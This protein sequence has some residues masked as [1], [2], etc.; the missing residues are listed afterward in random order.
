MAAETIYKLQP[1]RT[2]HLRG[3]DRRGAAAAMVNASATGFEVKGIFRD[4]A[5]FAVV[6]LWDADNFFE[7]PRLKY[8]P[9]FDFDGLVLQ[10][11]MNVSGVQSI[12]SIKHNWIDWAGI[13][14]TKE[15][16]TSGSVK[17]FSGATGPAQPLGTRT[18]ATATFTV[19]GSAPQAWDRVTLWYQNLA[20]D[21]IV[22]GKTWAEYAFFAA[23]AGHLHSITVG[24]TAYVY[25]E[26][27]DVTSAY[28]A[29]QLIS[30]MGSDPA[31]TASTGSEA[32]YVRLDRKKDDGTET[33]ISASGNL[34][35]S[36]FQVG[37]KWAAK[38]LTDQINAADYGGVS[39]PLSASRSN[40]TITV[41]AE[42]AG[43]DGNF[44]S[45][46]SQSKTATLA[47]SPANTKFGGGLTS[48]SWRVT[49]DFSA[50]GLTKV[51][52]LWMTLAPELP[53]GAAFEDTEWT[54]AVSNWSVSDANG[55]RA[56]KV[57]SPGSVR[58]DS[59]NAWAKYSGSGWAEES[60]WFDRGFARRASVIGDKV[61]IKYSCQSAHDLYVGTSLAQGRGVVAVKVDGVATADLATGI[62]DSVAINTRRRI[63]SG[64]A[65]GE[66]RVEL[67]LLALAG[68]NPPI[69]AGP[70][71]FDFLEAVVPG[72]VPD[73][74]ITYPGVTAAIDYDTDHTYKLPPARLAWN[75]DRLGLH[76]QVNEYVGVFWWNQRKRDGGTFKTAAVAFGGTWAA[77]DSITLDFDGTE[78]GKT[79]FAKDTAESI[80]QHFVY[81]INQTFV[82]VWA[83]LDPE[84]ETKIVI[85]QH[86]PEWG[87]G[88]TVSV[89]SA[90]GTAVLAG[91]LSGGVEGSWV[92]DGAASE[93]LNVAAKAWHQDFFQEVAVKGWGAVAAYSMEL[94]EPPE[95]LGAGA[96]F[97]S[98]Y[99]DG[100]PVA[101]D[102]GF[103]NLNSVHCSFTAAMAA[104]QSKV[105]AE[106]AA[107]MAAA[108][109]TPWLQFGEF[110][111]WFFS[112]WAFNVSGVSGMEVNTG[113]AHA[114]Q[115][116]ETVIVA[117]TRVLDGT[118]TVVSVPASNRVVVSGAARPGAWT[119]YG[120]IRG[121]G[122]GYYDQETAA[123]AVTAL[124]RALATFRTQDDDP[125]A[126]NGGADAAFLRS[127]MKSHIDTIRAAVLAAV[128][129]AKFEILFPFDVNHPS[130]Y[131]TL[132]LPYPQGGRLN[133]RVN[134]P[135][136]FL[137]KS[138]SGLDR[139]KVEAL[140]WGSF[141]RNLDR[142][143]ES[144][145]FAT[146]SP[147][148]WALADTA[149]LMPIFNGG[150]PWES[151]FLAA[152]NAGVPLIVLWAF[153][154]L[155][156]YSWPLPLP[157]NGGTVVFN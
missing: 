157:K 53:D 64:V 16:G 19:A 7:H 82:A 18:K 150:C 14:Y 145:R 57:A 40:A 143:K 35:E 79:V 125:D 94:V 99:P 17:L 90:D 81:A 63:A 131:H 84:D 89:D 24:E 46:Y 43:K 103:A 4:M 123:A 110:L 59:R 117:G 106:T 60:G 111:W 148:G 41:T 141:Y 135:V 66:H 96:V 93:A 91:S 21:Y 58:V 67:T 105:Y 129:S 101:T 76:G 1:N 77:E 52:R 39:I 142:S 11:D 80:A 132:D 55:K 83:E 137:A 65:A 144:I 119:G 126:V 61:E 108:G 31:V 140:S 116:G 127:R 156:L 95:D 138:G 9:D 2:M 26:E 122:M 32:H 10:F 151:E 22:P 70:F 154:H 102:T 100:W 27:A 86:S 133:A 149:Y 49:L 107:I 124:G 38:Q 54:V 56:L 153:D 20:F 69:P 121:G 45:M 112:R 155:T 104:Y 48:S 33:P 3:F 130:C 73:P 29:G 98:R 152:V 44:L 87:I 42:A 74:S 12:D 5:D 114:F 85:H 34:S 47:V 36:I 134:L 75:L 97:A 8:L 13:D 113:A 92:I 23:G 6:T 118:R 136:E 115:V 50:L 71:Y 109:L 78:I 30:Q 37:P 128:P 25:T 139:M 88:L 62:A 120:S 28:I 146:S 147:M 72:D 68:T 15:D 51:R